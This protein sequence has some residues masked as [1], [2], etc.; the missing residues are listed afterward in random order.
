MVK[1]FNSILIPVD[2]SVNTNL[3]VK[4]GHELADTG[5]VIHL[6][7][8]QNFSTTFFSGITK[9]YLP[10]NNGLYDRH[11]IEKYLAEWKS[12]IRDCAKGI[13]V[14]TW[15]T[16]G[17]SIQE[18][19]EKKAIQL[20][21]NLIIIGKNSQHSW[22]PILNT[23]TSGLI[24]RHTGIAVMTVKPGSSDN[25]I[26]KV[27]VPVSPKPAHDKMD[28]IESISKKFKMRLYLV[29]IVDKRK[30]SADFYASSLLQVY[31]WVKTTIGCPVEYAV[32]QGRN[33]ARTILTYATRINADILLVYPETES[34]ISWM[35]NEITD[36]LPPSTKVEIFTVQPHSV[37]S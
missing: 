14:C 3:A 6:L 24:V 2:F 22:F 25:K 32:L 31:N 26:R 34:K 36:V 35:N 20:D 28:L 4:K 8:V 30:E 33:R 16:T 9:L 5:T 17:N 11:E 12:V 7:H 21:V 18:S 1:S 13:K 29:A 37:T 15:I 19:I 27:I 23:V 10:R